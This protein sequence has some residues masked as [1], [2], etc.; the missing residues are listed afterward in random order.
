MSAKHKMSEMWNSVNVEP[1]IRVAKEVPARMA[2][3]A[4]FRLGPYEIVSPLGAG[5]MGEVYRARDTRLE[6]DVAI[7]VLPER[8][9]TDRERLTRFEREARSA[10]ALNHPNVVTIYDVGEEG[11]I[12]YIA[13]EL[14]EG[15][16]LRELMAAGALPLRELLQIGSQAAEGLARAH[17]GGI[18]HRDLKP[19]NLMVSEDGFVKILDFG[20]AKMTGSGTEPEVTISRE[21]T[22]SGAVMGT[23][24]YMSP[25]QARGRPLDFRSDQFSLGCI[26]YEMATGRRPFDRDTAAET[27]TAIIR[28]E[29]EPI[30]SVNARIPAPLCWIVERCLAKDPEQRY[31]STR[32]LA[33][34]VAAVRN[35]F[36]EVS[37]HTRLARPVNLPV[38]HTSFVG[39][40]RERAALKEMM[41]QANVSVVTMTGPGGIG[42]TRLALEVA[43]EIAD[44]FRGG[45]HF[46]PLAPVSDPDAIATAISQVLGVREGA[47]G[48]PLTALREYL[49]QA[50]ARDPM[51]LLLDGFEHL[52]AAALL[53]AELVK[54]GPKL[55]ILVTSRSPLHIY[56]E[57]EFSVLPLAVPDPTAGVEEL[58]CGDAI[59]LFLQRAAAVK[60]DFA[61]TEE[62]RIAIAEI[63]TRLD[64][65]PLAIELAAARV[66]LLSPAAMRTRLEKRL[67]LL[68]GGARDLPAR[69]QTLR[70][71]IDWSYE[72]LG[73]A[74]Q[75]LFRRLSVFV[76]GFT[77]EAAEAVCDVKSD[78]ELDLLDGV[79]SLMDKSLL[80]K[81]DRA[82]E[83]P[84]FAMLE[85]IR[86]YGL[87]QLASGGEEPLTK[88]VH[89]AYFVVFA[90]DNASERS[91]GFSGPQSS[92]KRLLEEGSGPLDQ[93][94]IEHDNCL[95]AL[96][97]LIEKGE[98]DWGLR[99]GGALFQFWEEREYLAEGRDRLRQLLDLPG[100]GGATRLRARA[101]FAAGVLAGP[102]A[103]ARPHFEE[104]LRISRELD[105]RRGIAVALNALAVGAQEAG[106][107]ARSRALLE[108]SVGLW[109]ELGDPVAVVRG[110]SNLASVARLERHF[111]EALVLFEE[112]LS[113]SRQL[114]DR[115]G[116]AG[117]LNH[118]GDVAR[119]QGD[120]S[121]ARCFYEQG[122][123]MFREIGDRLGVAGSL[124]DL[125]NLER[126]Q[127]DFATA[128]RLY[129]ES[130]EGFQ[131]L[132]H[133]RGSARLLDCFAVSAAAQSQQ[134]RAL[135]LAG[136][137]AALRETIGA[138][139]TPAEQARLATSLE[140]A[141]G[142]LSDA[143][144]AAAWMQGW[145][146]PVEKAIALAIAA[147]PA[148]PKS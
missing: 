44:G 96:D 88:R 83:E 128:H 28:E 118:K 78:L 65:L 45:V 100:A 107:L 35:R 133:K 95:A 60:P 142:A 67:Q 27:L 18:L 115:A 122:L 143:A 125:G 124:G 14:V 132:D 82:G 89:A 5:G 145:A 17:S 21:L 126:D 51:L 136:A 104:G 16:T 37:P 91:K 26:L 41:G 58:S 56:G 52:M 77:L 53:V 22:M 25:E 130:L 127:S 112:C 116:M 105:D 15:K 98:A 39:R 86:E 30:G 42:K 92:A 102:P 46:V 87:E 10:S 1:G 43:R 59:S 97:W 2:L 61:L 108:E 121:S 33:R 4:G 114:G 11:S 94:E 20:L 32:D 70:G 12:F 38:Q 106:D 55:K 19:D 119:E 47:S 8:L 101:L 146:M 63:C 99:L 66:K 138:V 80:Q 84:R 75:K 144:G 48:T 29:P 31:A 50:A 131:E 57:H 24:P 3:A 140:P 147:E 81:T 9:A 111:D 6:R 79:A 74:E 110:L 40:A 72:L 141:R 134:E 90:E 137:A 36:L 62:N 71:A 103:A 64:G 120:V 129:R 68:T 69:Q 76:G 7:K 23:V 73:S 54:V 85:T 117:G 139:L 135:R 34:D 148:G 93:F 123:V 109:R 113:I 49:H 13:M